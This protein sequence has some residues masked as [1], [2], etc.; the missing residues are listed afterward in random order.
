MVLPCEADP[1]ASGKAVAISVL[2]ATVII[3]AARRE[4]KE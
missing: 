3:A 4:M 2:L 1:T